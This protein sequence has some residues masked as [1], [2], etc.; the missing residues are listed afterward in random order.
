MTGEGFP[1]IESACE[2]FKSNGG[3]QW[4]WEAVI[5][6]FKREMW[7]FPNG[8][9]AFIQFAKENHSESMGR[10]MEEVEDFWDDFERLMIQ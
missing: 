2:T 9:I 5:A 7:M 10:P 4:E 8:P 6:A 3:S 1:A